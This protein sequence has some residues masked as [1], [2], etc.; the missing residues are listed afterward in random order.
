MRTNPTSCAGPYAWGAQVNE[1]LDA[2]HANDGE[3]V[4]REAA[5]VAAVALRIALC[6]EVAAF[7]ERSGFRPQGDATLF[8]KSV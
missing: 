4:A 3:D 1:L 5:Q 6:C 8:E 2:I 7:R